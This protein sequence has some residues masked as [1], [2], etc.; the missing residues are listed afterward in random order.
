MRPSM[1][2][3]MD[4]IMYLLEIEWAKRLK[5]HNQAIPDN[6]TDKSQALEIYTHFQ[7]INQFHKS[8]NAPVP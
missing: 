2:K 8:Q 5:A 6:Q 1:W 7:G 3:K 4:D